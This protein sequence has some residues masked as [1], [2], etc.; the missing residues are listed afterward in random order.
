[1]DLLL[2]ILAIILVVFGVATLVNGSL[3]WGL[4]LIVVGLF[5]GGRGRVY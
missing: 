2:T 4:I 5:L 3:L 1:M